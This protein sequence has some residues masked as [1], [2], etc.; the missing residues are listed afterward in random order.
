MFKRWLVSIVLNAIAIIVVAQLFSG[1]HIAGFGTAILASFVLAILNV[2]VKPFLIILT[3]P[4]TI[5]TLGLFL[6]VVNAITLWI[7]QGLFGSSFQID[8][9]GLA[10]GAAIVISLINLILTRLIS[11]TVR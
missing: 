8:S 9:F 2:L 4:I 11:D 5:F 7:T 1:F 10:I 3:L 6:F